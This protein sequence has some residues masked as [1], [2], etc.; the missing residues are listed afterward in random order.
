MPERQFVSAAPNDNNSVTDT[1]F[2]TVTT[3]VD[4]RKLPLKPRFQAQ[5]AYRKIA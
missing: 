5:R 3:D 2:D 1:A 4:A